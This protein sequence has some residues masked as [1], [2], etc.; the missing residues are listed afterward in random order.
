MGQ[1][2]GL[3]VCFH[4]NTEA[5][6]TLHVLQLIITLIGVPPQRH[7][8]ACGEIVEYVSLLLHVMTNDLIYLPHILYTKR[9][10]QL[11]P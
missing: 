11:G 5:S 2:I 7:I 9:M 10:G 8:Q 4:L 1:L 6:P 3:R